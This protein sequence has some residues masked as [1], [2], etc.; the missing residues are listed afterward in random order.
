MCQ[1]INFAYITPLNAIRDSFRVLNK[2]EE[3]KGQFPV[4]MANKISKRF[5]YETFAECLEHNP[6]IYEEFPEYKKAFEI[7][8][9]I[10]GKV[11]GVSIHAGGCGIVDTTIND[12]MGMIR[13]GEGEQVIQ[14]DKRL[15]EDI[16]IIKFD[17]LGVK[18]LKLVQDVV[19]ETGIDKW[20]ININNPKFEFDRESYDLL[21]EANTNAIFQVESSGM[22]DLLLRLQPHN[23]EDLSAVIALYRPDSMGALEEFI[24]CK[25][26]KIDVSYIHDDMIPIL[27]TTYGCLIYQEQL[28]DVVR[29]FGGRTYGGADLF[30]KGI[31]KKDQKLVQQES[32]KLYV[33]I[34]ENGYNDSVSRTISDDMRSKGG[35]LFN[36]SHS[37]S[38]AVL[39]LQTAYLKKHYPVQFYKAL[40]N[41]RKADNGKLN[42]YIKDALDNGVEVLLPDINK[43]ELDFSIHNNKIVFGLSAISGIG[44]KILTPILEERN[45]NGLFKSIN[46]FI[47]RTNISTANFITLVKA[48]AIP[49]KNK[50]QTLV[51]YAKKINKK[52]DYKPVTTLPTLSKLESDWGIDTNVIKTKSE[53]LSLYNKKREEKFIQQQEETLNKKLFIF[54]EKYLQDPEMWEFEA[55]SVFLTN[56]PFNKITEKITD[57]NESRNGNDCV[58]VGVI[59]NKI[60]KKNKNKQQYAFMT[61]ATAYGLVE[62]GCWASQ[63]SMYSGLIE[64]HNRIAI[65]CNKQDDKYSVKEIKPYKQWLKDVGL[66]K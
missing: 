30:R 14:V 54:K 41:L 33:E 51:N 31:G 53:R 39:A 47:N 60:I 32:D 34:L 50:Y 37:F 4:N 45:K 2:E 38:Y 61:I 58:I 19:N 3:T 40:F 10:S 42:K 56:N 11:R 49:S 46:D 63:Y 22:K 28:L 20:D 5:A 55:L 62:V 57:F 13:G 26:G 17:L 25:H 48:G 23:I 9:K 18:T 27:D 66:E 15:I 59:A 43:S 24:D 65:L 21:S 16:G 44:E 52:S 29:V 7:A 12:Y 8:K 35:Y 64:K 6:T 1:V 36:K